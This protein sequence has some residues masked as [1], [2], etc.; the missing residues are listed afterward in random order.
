M[1]IGVY[2]DTSTITNIDC[3][4]PEKG[5]P[6]IGGT[7]YCFITLVSYYQKIY[8][9]DEIIQIV[10]KES[11]L[12][13]AS[14]TIYVD[15]IYEAIEKSSFLELDMLL[16]RA[17]NDEKVY[18]LIDENKINT[19]TWGHNFYYSNLC[20]LIA[21]SEFVKRNVFVGKQMHDRYIDHDISSKSIYI[22]NMY[23]EVEEVR[24]NSNGYNVTYIG[25]LIPSKGFHILA[26]SWKK[27]LQKI[28]QARLQVIGSGQLYNK[29]SKLGKY[30]IA[31]EQ[32]ETKFMR[33]LV[34]KKGNVLDSVNFFGVLY[35]LS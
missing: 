6:G 9:K 22:Y 4:Y 12:P 29:N 31:E 3:R 32:Y 5:N 10:N 1:R 21:K 13:S 34:D 18:Q 28:P 17:V 24:S 27:V 26:K 20:E 33:Y 35:K 2:Y 16:I 11:I 30:G 7:E 14:Q 19:I 25:S 15:N 8:P 23:P